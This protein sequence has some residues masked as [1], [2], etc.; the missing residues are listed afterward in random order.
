MSSINPTGA[1]RMSLHRNARGEP[2]PEHL[3]KVTV[4]VHHLVARP[5]VE[6]WWRGLVREWCKMPL[7]RTPAEYVVVPVE[8]TLAEECAILAA[9]HDYGAEEGMGT[10][11][12]HDRLGELTE[13][14][15]RFA[16]LAVAVQELPDTDTARLMVILSGIRRLLFP[17]F[18]RDFRAVQWGS[19]QFTFTVREAAC[20]AVMRKYGGWLGGDAILVNA[21]EAYPVQ[22]ELVRQELEGLETCN[23]LRD[24]FKANPAWGALIEAHPTRKNLFRLARPPQPKL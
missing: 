18:S 10:I 19:E 14:A 1:T 4:A 15:I 5:G 24:V 16:V 17:S 11:G 23:R 12:P 13:D 6:E 22:S 20:L 7:G 3:W 2:V 8:P 9:V 21:S